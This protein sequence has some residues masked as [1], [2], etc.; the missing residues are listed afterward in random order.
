MAVIPDPPAGR[1]P[2]SILIHATFIERQTADRV[3]PRLRQRHRGS[4]VAA[5]RAGY[6][7]SLNA[8]WKTAHLEA[9]RTI[10]APLRLTSE[11]IDGLFVVTAQQEKQRPPNTHA[12][13]SAHEW[14]ISPDLATGATKTFNLS[15]VDADPR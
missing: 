5:H 4:R 13:N 1:A 6:A 15:D 3:A 11:G 8:S 12:Y 7:V 14:V 9:P 10:G 2:E